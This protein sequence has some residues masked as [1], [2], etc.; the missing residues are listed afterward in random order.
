MECVALHLVICFPFIPFLL[1]VAVAQSMPET[2]MSCCISGED[3]LTTFGREGGGRAIRLWYCGWWTV[4]NAPNRH[5]RL[6]EVRRYGLL[7]VSLCVVF[8]QPKYSLDSF[9]LFYNSLGLSTIGSDPET[10]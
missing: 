1:C 8:R 10:C 9:L 5:R 4:F 2:F 7:A 6:E 3:T